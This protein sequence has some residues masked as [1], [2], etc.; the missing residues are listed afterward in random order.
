MTPPDPLQLPD[1]Q[2][3]RRL[4]DAVPVGI[5]LTDLEERIVYANAA[6]C[7]V[8]G[9]PLPELLGRVAGQ[10]ARLSIRPADR[11]DL[12]RALA[13]GQ[14][15]RQLL[16]SQSADG[17]DRWT[18]LA[19]HTLNGEGGQPLHFVGTLSDVDRLVRD[20]QA[21]HQAAHT[22]ALTGAGNRRA[23]D[24]AMQ[25]QLGDPASPP[26]EQR[27]L[28]LTLVVLDVNGL[29]ALN[30]RLGHPAGDA[31]LL[32]F[33]AA[34]RLACRAQD[35]V[36]RLG[37]DEFALLF[38]GHLPEGVWARRAQ[39]MLEQVR[40]SGFPEASFAHG[41]AHAPAE[42]QDPERLHALADARMYAMK[43]QMQE[44]TDG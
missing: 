43:R 30:D 4:L 29:K 23:F 28:P 44:G 27:D 5:V 15:A 18:L 9:A 42:A 22:D 10:V 41:A 36:Y 16:R 11:E 24:A 8:V 40:Q 35:R 17:Q 13:S 12:L 34:A 37:G 6:Y 1:Q 2:T 39:A 33:T 14:V 25:A 19:I 38:M 26:G 3:L 20:G 32:A 31:L 7:A 21:W